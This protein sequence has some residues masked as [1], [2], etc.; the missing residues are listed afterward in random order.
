MPSFYTNRLL[1]SYCLIIL[2]VNF[3]SCSVK[4]TTESKIKKSDI[5]ASSVSNVEYLKQ[6]IEEAENRLSRNFRQKQVL[7]LKSKRYESL[8]HKREDLNVREQILLFWK[9]KKI[10]DNQKK[11]LLQKCDDLADLWRKQRKKLT[12]KRFQL[13]FPN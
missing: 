8:Y 1:I 6:S 11:E 4:S 12:L 3:C 9:D 7:F 13:G 10:T 2:V 5:L